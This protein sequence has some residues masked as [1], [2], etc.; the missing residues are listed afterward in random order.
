MSG[1]TVVG[2]AAATIT[3]FT[4]SRV[5]PGAVA[6]PLSLAATCLTHG[7]RLMSSIL[8]WPVCGSQLGLASAA[9]VPTPLSRV[10]VPWLAADAAPVP[11]TVTTPAK[12]VAATT[13]R[14]RM[15]RVKW[16]SVVM[17][18]PLGLLSCARAVSGPPTVSVVRR[19][20]NAG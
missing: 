13:A 15:P 10:G 7:G 1:G 3:T 2:S 9:L 14:T 8:I 19:P 16:R 4:V 17:E 20:G 5:T 6:P 12:Q 11:L 18:A